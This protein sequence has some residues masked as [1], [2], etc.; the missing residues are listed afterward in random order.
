MYWVNH[1]VPVLFGFCALVYIM[2]FIA[3]QLGY[4]DRFLFL[5]ERPL[6][7][8]RDYNRVC[9]ILFNQIHQI[10]GYDELPNNTLDRVEG[11]AE[12]VM[13]AFDDRHVSVEVYLPALI[14]GRKQVDFRYK[15]RLADVMHSAHA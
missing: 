12:K 15:I 5:R 3:Y 13:M 2:G 7:E 9:D 8:R 4:I 10:S 6:R 1:F 11:A 14:C